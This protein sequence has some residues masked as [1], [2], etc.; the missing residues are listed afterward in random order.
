MGA[1]ASAN[2]QMS[3]FELE[4]DELRREFIINVPLPSER[5]RPDSTKPK[6]HRYRAV[7]VALAASLRSFRAAH[8]LTLAGLYR[9]LGI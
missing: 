7:D 4:S 3:D 1:H 2:A 9:Q 6:Q 5:L 8:D